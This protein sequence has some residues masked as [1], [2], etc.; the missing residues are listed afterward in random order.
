M[1]LIGTAP[2]V[3]VSI[4]ILVASAAS[5]LLER[6]LLKGKRYIVPKLSVFKC[7][8]VSIRVDFE[9]IFS[10]SVSDSSGTISRVVIRKTLSQRNISNTHTLTFNER[11][12]R[13]GFSLHAFVGSIWLP[14]VSLSIYFYEFSRCQYHMA[15]ACTYYAHSKYG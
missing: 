15:I 14:S 6:A 13:L 4:M 10:I 12:Q 3:T 7:P 1:F 11:V 5:C 8:K 2:L 9:S